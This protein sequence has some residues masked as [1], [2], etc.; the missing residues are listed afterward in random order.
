MTLHLLLFFWGERKGATTKSCM[1]ICPL[2]STF[3][4]LATAI[5]YILAGSYYALAYWG[6]QQQQDIP[7]ST[8]PPRLK[9]SSRVEVRKYLMKVAVRHRDCRFIRS[10]LMKMLLVSWILLGYISCSISLSFNKGYVQP[11][12]KSGAYDIAKATSSTG[13][14]MPCIILVTPFLDQNIG[15]GRQCRIY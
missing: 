6:N 3:P 13:I 10:S 7:V 12:T 15:S 4:S 5:T 8:P 2:T 1:I 14:A 11:Q 9:W